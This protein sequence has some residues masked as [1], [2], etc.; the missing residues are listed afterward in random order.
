V[1]RSLQDDDDDNTTMMMM[2]AN[3]IRVTLV[4]SCLIVPVQGFGTRDALALKRQQGL[5]LFAVRPAKKGSHVHTTASDP[6]PDAAATLEGDAHIMFDPMAGHKGVDMARAH[7]CA[8]H[9]G[10]CSVEEM[11]ELRDSY[12]Y[13]GRG[14]NV[15]R[16][17]LIAALAST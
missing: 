12:V 1:R 16:F 10:Q 8:D 17:E 11:Q 6:H 4:L 7:A 15:V 2:P 5:L 9:F 14:V 3:A 13:G